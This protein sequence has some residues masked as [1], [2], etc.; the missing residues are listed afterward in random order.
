MIHNKFCI[1]PEDHLFN[2]LVQV[3]IIFFYLIAQ[4]PSRQEKKAAALEKGE[5]PTFP[6]FRALATAAATPGGKNSESPPTKV[7]PLDRFINTERR[8]PPPPRSCKKQ[9][10]NVPGDNEDSSG[11]DS[12]GTDSSAVKSGRDKD[13]D[14]AP[15]DADEQDDD[16]MSGDEFQASQMPL[17]QPGPT[18]S[19]DHGDESPTSED[20]EADN[21][22]DGQGGILGDEDDPL[23]AATSTEKSD[24]E[25]GEEDEHNKPPILD[26]K[27]PDASKEEKCCKHKL[28]KMLVEKVL[29][30]DLTAL[31]KDDPWAQRM[32]CAE[33][34][35]VC[36]RNVPVVKKLAK[37]QKTHLELRRADHDILL[38]VLRNQTEMNGKLDMILN[39]TIQKAT[40]KDASFP[41]HDLPIPP[42]T[43]HDE[44]MTLM[45]TEVRNEEC[46]LLVVHLFM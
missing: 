12:S 44:L 16:E 21:D 33:A 22:Q 4:A 19:D 7:D 26:D 31:G 38:Q 29:S 9:K 34:I 11:T 14:Y 17:T 37:T 3:L 30:T 46:A 8:S 18:S 43:S 2:C 23:P 35:C 20:E 39:R 40:K 6:T 41:S 15:N 32:F 13:K 42:L 5:T 25:Q 27:S 45:E 28:E 1:S 10:P 24:E 36:V